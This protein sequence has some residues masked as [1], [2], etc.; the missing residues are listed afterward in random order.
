MVTGFIIA[1]NVFHLMQNVV[2]GLPFTKLC[3]GDED[4]QPTKLIIIIPT[5]ISI[6]FLTFLFLI[7]FKTRNNLSK[8]SDQHLKNLPASN[9][10]T[11]LDTQVLCFIILLFYGIKIFIAYLFLFDIVSFKFTLYVNNVIQLSFH[12]VIISIVFPIYIILKT[13]RYLP[14]L[15]DDDSPL[16]IQNN[17]FYATRISQVQE[18]PIVAESRF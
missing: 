1:F 10:L 8:L 16:I 9:A 6:I 5:A 14:R 4:E 15:W 12:N 11:Y 7:S 3:L 13:R 2:H 18:Q 17:D